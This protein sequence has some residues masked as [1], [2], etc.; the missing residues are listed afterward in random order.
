MAAYVR[1]RR[2]S[3]RLVHACEGLER[4]VLLAA[5]VLTDINPTPGSSN[6]DNF[7]QV[8]AITYFVA[9]DGT[10][11]RELWRSDGTEGG[12]ILVKDIVSGTG[13][14]YPVALTNVNGTIYF[15]AETPETGRELWKSD[16]TAN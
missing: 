10:H 11:G 9:D 13:N 15:S 6:P 3:G 4:R 16:G 12:T 2:G 8:G 14:S 1:R 5:Q 7:V